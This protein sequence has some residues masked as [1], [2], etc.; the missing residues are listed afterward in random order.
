MPCCFKGCKQQLE[1]RAPKEGGG[2]AVMAA[3]DQLFVGCLYVSL[4]GTTGVRRLFLWLLLMLCTDFRDSGGTRVDT[5]DGGH[6]R[7]W[8]A[9]TRG[10]RHSHR[11]LPRRR[12]IERQTAI[13]GRPQKHCAAH[14][15]CTTT[16]ADSDTSLKRRSPGCCRGSARRSRCPGPCA[17]R[18]RRP[19]PW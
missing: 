8:G 18:S 14:R 17:R 11:R 19:G 7:G 9:E 3:S 4:S 15:A 13:P 5:R 16:H 6:T 1:A 2:T 12:T 10:P